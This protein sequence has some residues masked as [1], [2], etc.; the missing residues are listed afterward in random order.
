MDSNVTQ[1]TEAM[2]GVMAAPIEVVQCSQTYT[3]IVAAITAVIFF[4]VGSVASKAIQEA[5]SSRRTT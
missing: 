3:T 2:A 5:M 4:V 1:T